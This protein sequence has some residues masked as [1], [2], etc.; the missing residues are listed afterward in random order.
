MKKFVFQENSFEEKFNTTFKK[1]IT[2]FGELSRFLLK[3]TEHRRKEKP[4]G[5]VYTERESDTLFL[6][7]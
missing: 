3:L 6:V 4:S 7:F 2:C 5:Q 1:K